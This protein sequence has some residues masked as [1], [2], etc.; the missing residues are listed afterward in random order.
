MPALYQLPRR[1]DGSP[2]DSVQLVINNETVVLAKSY[3]VSIHYLQVP[4]KFTISVGSGNL[5]KEIYAKYP[6]GSPFVLYV[7]GVAQFQGVLDEVRRGN[8]GATEVVLSGRDAMAHLVDDHLREDKSFTHSSYEDLVKAALNGSGAEPYALFYDPN[9]ARLAVAGKPITET[10][11]VQ[12]GEINP[13][14]LRV[15]AVEPVP[16]QDLRYS[17][18]DI[19]LR[20]FNDVTRIKGYKCENPIEW[21]AGQ[22]WYACLKKEL[23]R[24]GLMLRASVDPE[25]LDAYNFILAA[26]VVSKP[27]FGLLHLRGER[28]FANFATV[29]PPQYRNS[30]VG[31]FAHYRILGRAGGGKNGRKQVEGTYTDEEMVALGFDWKHFVTK[32]DYAKTTDHATYLARRAAAEHRRT[33]WELVYPVKG[34]VAP[35]F[36]DPAQFAVWGIDNIVRVKDEENGIEGDYWIEGVEMFGGA[37]GTK[38]EINLMRPEDLVFGQD[39]FDTGPKIKKKPG[40]KRRRNR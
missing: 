36:E 1:T 30:V 27:V 7:G 26:P 19:D 9:A 38:T 32:D 13:N 16:G 31:R 34:H 21:K 18:L 10:V 29:Y 23:D 37:D 28:R 39:Q 3:R 2:D 12:V 35:L 8:P 40:F 4:A 33:N 15:L 25:G 14:D 20:L 24:A 6:P 17:P 11:K 5:A 22:T